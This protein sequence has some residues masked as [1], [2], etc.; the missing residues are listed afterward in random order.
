M[1]GSGMR[2][3][4]TLIFLTFAFI[5]VSA[6][7]YL[8]ESFLVEGSFLSS[9]FLGGVS[10]FLVLLVLRLEELTP[11]VDCFV[12]RFVPTFLSVE[13][14]ETDELFTGA[15]DLLVVPVF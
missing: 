4:E 15:V 7:Y 1:A 3:A 10:T 5:L 12:V 6:F 14:L 2:T 13:G 11:V 9:L 8:Q